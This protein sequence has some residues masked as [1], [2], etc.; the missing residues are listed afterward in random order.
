MKQ[1]GFKKYIPLV[2]IKNNSAEVLKSNMRIV[3]ACEYGLQIFNGNLG[4]FNNNKKMIKNWFNM[5]RISGK[6]KHPNEKPVELLE[7]VIELFTDENETVL[8][9]CM[10]SGSTAVACINTKRDFIG[11]ELEQK[12]YEIAIE[13]VKELFT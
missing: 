10:G 2:F 1:Y 13:R 5:R 8:D 7:E 4:K 3:G 12:Y 9:M 11:I 6:K